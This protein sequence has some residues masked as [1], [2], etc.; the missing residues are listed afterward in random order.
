MV[1]NWHT[2]WFNESFEL[3][4]QYNKYRH[5]NAVFQA[6]FCVVEPTILGGISLTHEH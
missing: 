6:T 2:N 4:D 1:I 5:H 3:L